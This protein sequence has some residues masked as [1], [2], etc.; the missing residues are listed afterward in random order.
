M[1]G[2][3]WLQ[4]GVAMWGGAGGG[5]RRFRLFPEGNWKTWQTLSWGAKRTSDWQS[6][7]WLGAA[8]ALSRDSDRGESV[9]GSRGTWRQSEC[10]WPA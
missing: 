3:R 7:G 8:V 1:T 6:R 10:G 2:V 9:S 4:P 5:Q